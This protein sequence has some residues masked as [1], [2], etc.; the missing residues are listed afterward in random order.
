MRI[1][2]TGAGGFVGRALVRHLE[3]LGWTVYR[4]IRSRESSSPAEATGKP[5]VMLDEQTGA[6]DLPGQVDGMVHLAGIAH[7]R[8]EGS[9]AYRRVN[10]LWTKNLSRRAAVVGIPHFVFA[11]TVKVAGESHPAPID[12]SVPPSPSDAY[13]ASKAEAEAMLE[14]VSGQSSLRTTILRPPLVYGPGVK[15]NFLSLLRAVNSGIPLPL[16]SVDNRRSLIYV[17][18]LVSAIEACL[19]RPLDVNRTFYISDDRDVS[20]PRLI[21]AIATALGKKPNLFAFPPS[22]LR[23]I[24]KLAGRGEQIGRL[25]DSLQVD[26]TR[27]KTELGWRPPYSMSEGL[28]STAAWYRGSR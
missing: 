6:F 28:A 17:G 21:E 14:E 24:G 19:K 20:T 11:S 12:E 9:D 3:A 13:A 18:N 27:I 25:L 15:A 5:S 23:G 2:V 16:A 8:V 7:T 26:I 10:A 4:G 1:L 22:L